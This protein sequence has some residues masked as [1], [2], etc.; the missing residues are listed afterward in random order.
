MAVCRDVDVTA[1]RPAGPQLFIVGGVHIHPHQCLTEWRARERALF[2]HFGPPPRGYIDS[3]LIPTC[4]TRLRP[5]MRLL[6]PSD[7]IL[8]VKRFPGC[9]LFLGPVWWP[10]ILKKGP[11]WTWNH[12]VYNGYFLLNGYII[13]PVRHSISTVL[14]RCAHDAQWSRRPW[15]WSDVSPPNAHPP[16]LVTSN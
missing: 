3:R 7:L 16:R 13:R 14:Y 6:D 9:L 15:R 5:R 12:Y 1:F 10:L 8:M 4:G 11:K 2:W